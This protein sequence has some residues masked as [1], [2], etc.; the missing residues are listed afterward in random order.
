MIRE[1]DA[2]YGQ[3]EPDQSEPIREESE[4]YLTPCEIAVLKELFT[5]KTAREVA[6]I[7][8]VS[9][10]TVHFH[11]QNVYAKLGV[12]NVMECYLVVMDRELL[13]LSKPRTRRPRTDYGPRERR[14]YL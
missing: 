13:T 14:V 12:R 1:L 10:R 9:H 4:P 3:E 8:C 7:L 11:A 6:D 2:L 5:G